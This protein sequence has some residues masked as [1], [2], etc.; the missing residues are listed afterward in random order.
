M[1]QAAAANAITGAGLTVGAVTTAFSDTMPAGRVISSTPAAGSVELPGAPVAL[2]ISRG[3]NDVTPPTVSIASPAAG[4]TVS[5]TVDVTA[6]AADNVGV[7][8]VQ[9]LLDGNLL[10][11][12]ERRVGKG[13]T[14]NTTTAANGTQTQ[15]GR[16]SAS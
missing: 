12:E 3:S 2:V 14:W 11:S 1:S 6:T 13:A 7:V 9:F 16:W 4:A 10:R 15:G 5:R 8:G